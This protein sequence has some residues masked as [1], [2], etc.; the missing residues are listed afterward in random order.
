MSKLLRRISNGFRLR[1]TIPLHCGNYS[2]PRSIGFRNYSGWLDIY[3]VG[4]VRKNTHFGQ[5]FFHRDVE[6][7]GRGG[8]SQSTS[9][10]CVRQPVALLTSVHQYGLGRFLPCRRRNPME[11][12]WSCLRRRLAVLDLRDLKQRK[13]AL[14]RAAFKARVLYVCWRADET[15]HTMADKLGLA[16]GGASSGSLESARCALA[17]HRDFAC[18]CG[19]KKV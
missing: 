12:F 14:S 7:T 8:C 6:K 18:H 2:V 16:Y 5:N 4:R 11:K 3:S 10:S 15:L 1:K 17:V 19:V 13:V 9:P